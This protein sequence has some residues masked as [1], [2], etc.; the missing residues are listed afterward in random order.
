MDI[1]SD[2]DWIALAGTD[3]ANMPEL[4]LGTVSLTL[5]EDS[6]AVI[7][8]ATCIHMPTNKAALIA[9]TFDA[10]DLLI[11]STCDSNGD[12]SIYI[13]AVNIV[14]SGNKFLGEKA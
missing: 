14:L 2:N 7:S 1:A 8:G 5:A 10:I 9:L 6:S 13:D 11:G 12:S 4:S 3:Y